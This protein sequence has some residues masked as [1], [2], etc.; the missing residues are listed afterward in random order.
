MAA[1]VKVFVKVL[2]VANMEIKYWTK[3]CKYFRMG[4]CL[5]GED[6]TF[7]HV[8]EDKDELKEEK[9]VRVRLCNSFLYGNNCDRGEMC[10]YAHDMNLRTI[11]LQKKV[12]KLSNDVEELLADNRRLKVSLYDTMSASKRQSVY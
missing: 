5:K 10:R 7:L 8:E 11:V 12:T 2:E 4:R 1:K 3:P 9:D 6:C